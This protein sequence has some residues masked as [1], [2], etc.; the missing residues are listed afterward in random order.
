[1]A[2]MRR[3]MAEVMRFIRKRSAVWTHDLY[4]EIRTSISAAA[5]LS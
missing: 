2:V 4:E 3:R 5:S 1:M